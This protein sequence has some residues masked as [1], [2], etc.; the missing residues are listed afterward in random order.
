MRSFGLMQTD[1]EEY[2]WRGKAAT[3]GDTYMFLNDAVQQV[4]R[5]KNGFGRADVVF[6]I[7]NTLKSQIQ[8]ET[9]TIFNDAD[10]F[11]RRL[12][13]AMQAIALYE[14]TCSAARTAV[15]AWTLIGNK[16]LNIPKDVTKIVAEMI[17]RAR[18]DAEYDI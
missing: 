11:D 3:R 5:Y 4:T 2:R 15:D 16:R 18:E 8:L 17:W 10:D 7:G 12:K 14:G 9:R 1:G 13:C 6:A